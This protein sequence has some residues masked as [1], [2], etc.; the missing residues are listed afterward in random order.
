MNDMSTNSGESQKPTPPPFASQYQYQQKKSKWWIIPVVLISIL[1]IIGFF[2]FMIIGAFTSAIDDMFSTPEVVVKNKT[3]LQLDIEGISEI[4]RGNFFQ[5]FSGGSVGYFDVINAIERA[6]N[7]DNIEGIYYQGGYGFEGNA[8]AEGILNAIEKFKESGKFIYAYM[9]YMSE[10]QYINALP[11]DSIFMPEEAMLEINGFSAS[12][13]FYP[14]FFEKVGLK[15]NV[16]HFE[17]F[18]SYGESY[19]KMAYSDSSRY[20]LQMLLNA[21][22]DKFLAKLEKYRGIDRE[23]GLKIL[24][25]GAYCFEEAMKNGLVDVKATESQVKDFIAKKIGS[26]D[27][28]RLVSI[29]KYVRA[30]RS[31][32]PMEANL[33][34]DEIIDENINIAIVNAEGSIMPGKGNPVPFQ[35]NQSTIYSGQLVK[36]L[37]KVRDNKDIDGVI[38]R[39]NSPGGSVLASEEIYDAVLSLKK[40]KPV[41]ASMS[42]IAASGGYFIAMPCDKIYASAETIT[43]SIGVVS[44]LP[45]ISGTLDKLGVTTD[46]VKT[47]DGAT[48]MEDL[49]QSDD[50]KKVL[51]RFRAMSEKTYHRFI[52]RVAD[53]REMTFEQA[54]KYAKGRVW[55]GE[56]ALERG[57]IDG[58]GD[59][60]EVIALMKEELG[61]DRNTNVVISIYPSQKDEIEQLLS[62]FGIE[63]LEDEQMKSALSQINSKDLMT[64]SAAMNMSKSEFLQLYNTMPEQVQLNL[65]YLLS[66]M[67]I[68]KHE[69]MMFAMPNIPYIK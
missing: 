34:E 23:Q 54:H 28:L 57:L 69:R 25:E 50:Y 31:N 13:M 4:G 41:F 21:K 22:Q 6:A 16:V 45:N 9:P 24:E 39:I 47:N 33:G 5:T 62:M 52:Q 32:F 10:N 63:E 1:L 20:N 26:E 8:K 36:T 35:N 48:F 17:D 3:V 19:D 59:Q 61:V 14:G 27:K 53:N 64:I 12:G 18:K 2:G 58:L 30:N 15:Y 55:T 43:G 60:K 49:I 11:A 66:L 46:Q 37:M 44:A 68:S 65:E 7:D 51:E 56:Q 42:D 38:L 40:E 67:Q 29:K